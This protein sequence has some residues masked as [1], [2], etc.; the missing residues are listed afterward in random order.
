[1]SERRSDDVAF[2]SSDRELLA[3]F[4]AGEPAALER[5]YRHYAPLVAASLRRGFVSIRFRQPHELES[6][7]QEVFYRAFQ[8]RARMSY[9][10]LRP[11]R[12]FLGGIARHVVVDELRKR[13]R[14]PEDPIDPATLE[15]APDQG[16]TPEEA[17]EAR[18]ASEV[19]EAFLLTCD[20]RDRR[21]FQ[22]RFR[23][24][25]SQ[26]A[27]AKAAGLTRIQLR[28]WEG[29]LRKRLLLH[30]KRVKYV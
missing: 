30:L 3:G 20:D 29:K 7:V 9:D 15:D 16:G 26:E 13:R 10:G 27:A 12:D 2:L 17:L 18:Q 1:V 14:R 11:Y 24:D 28:R 25:L 8:E 6:A 21:L 4:R 19:V 23:D 5:V 22:L